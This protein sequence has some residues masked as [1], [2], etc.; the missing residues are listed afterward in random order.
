M[1][2]P[3][4]TP[5][6]PPRPPRADGKRD[7]GRPTKFT[8][9]ITTQLLAVVAQGNWRKTA[10]AVVGIDAVTLWQWIQKGKAEA[11]GPY[12]DFLHELIRVEGGAEKKVVDDWVRQSRTDW[13]AGAAFLALRY[14]SRWGQP[15]K[16]ELSGPDG[17]PLRVQHTHALDLTRLN[18]E[19]LR[20]LYEIAQRARPPLQVTAQEADAPTD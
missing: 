12:R 9:E 16:V 13:R 4:R 1:T 2:R 10:C 18:D 19:D 3:V 15:A 5:A 14:K 17:Q 11:S 8:P 7:T 6:K 20:T